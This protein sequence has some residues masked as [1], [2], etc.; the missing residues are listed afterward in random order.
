MLYALHEKTSFGQFYTYLYVQ[1]LNNNKIEPILWL[2]EYDYDASLIFEDKTLEK[3]MLNLITDAHLMQLLI[4]AGLDVQTKTHGFNLFRESNNYIEEISLLE[5]VLMN[6]FGEV[7]EVIIKTYEKNG[8]SYPESLTATIAQYGTPEQVKWWYGKK[9]PFTPISN[10]SFSA[11]EL[12][13]L[14]NNT[15]NVASIIALEGVPAQLSE[16]AKQLDYYAYTLADICKSQ[17]MLKLLLENGVGYTPLVYAKFQNASKTNNN[18]LAIKHLEANSQLPLEEIVEEVINRNN[19]EITTWI[20]DR[21]KNADENLIEDLARS[22]EIWLLEYLLSSSRYNEKIRAHRSA[23]NNTLLHYAVDNQNNELIVFLLE[24]GFSPNEKNNNGYSPYEML[25]ENEYISNKQE[26]LKT[27]ESYNAKAVYDEETIRKTFVDAIISGDEKKVFKYLRM[28]ANPNHEFETDFHVGYWDYVTETVEPIFFALNDR[29]EEIAELLLLYGANPNTNSKAES[30][31]GKSPLSLALDNNMH[32]AAR[33]LIFKGAN[34]E[35]TEKTGTGTDCETAQ[36]LKERIAAINSEI[37]NDAL[38]LESKSDY[39]DFEDEAYEAIRKEDKVKLQM[40]NTEYEIKERLGYYGFIDTLCAYS[41]DEFVLFFYKELFKNQTQL[42]PHHIKSFILNN[43]F[44]AYKALTETFTFNDSDYDYY[45][46]NPILTCIEHASSPYSFFKPV[47]R[48]DRS[49]HKMNKEEL[50]DNF[51]F[52]KTLSASSIENYDSVNIINSVRAD[53]K[54]AFKYLIE[55]NEVKEYRAF[56]NIVDGNIDSVLEKLNTGLDVNTNIYGFSLLSCAAWMNNNELVNN[57]LEKGAEFITKP[58]TLEW[59]PMHLRPEYWA[60]V[61]GNIPMMELLIEKG[62]FME[63]L[64]YPSYYDNRSVSAFSTLMSQD[65]KREAFK[66]LLEKQIIN[67]SLG[68]NHSTLLTQAIEFDMIELVKLLFNYFP[69]DD[70]YIPYQYYTYS[71]PKNREE[72]IGY[73]LRYSAKKTFNYLIE[74]SDI[75]PSFE[76]WW[77]NACDDSDMINWVMENGKISVEEDNLIQ[78]AQLALKAKNLDYLKEHVSKSDSE[79]LKRELNYGNYNFKNFIDEL[80][81]KDAIEMLEYLFP[82]INGATSDLLEEAIEHNSLNC[83]QYLLEKEIAWF[84]TDR[85]GNYY[86]PDYTNDYEVWKTATTAI[87]Q[88]EKLLH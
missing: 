33:M 58:E 77:L 47:I 46:Y 7:A 4:D 72:S 44:A 30:F 19:Q 82:Y 57:L 67:A 28:G 65:S 59:L 87:M 71:A 66:W 39:Y 14:A 48:G 51:E 85:Y 43:R 15:A 27:F 5:M 21:I 18:K 29:K 11:L 81:Q 8:L 20:L 50:N 23:D 76:F 38:N 34:L 31:K 63:Y 10:G 56:Q 37:L 36:T 41:S 61:N 1:A 45:K 55:F 24:K 32:N 70:Y 64:Y 17:T 75:I 9:N 52:I 74:T 25:L 16:Q 60:I 49:Q 78:I 62:A 54:E 26:L 12:A 42:P 86:I 83:F 6:Q 22:D 13:V 69:N 79:K 84:D 53:Y 40:L 88:K 68:D 2:K 73:A 35:F 3:G 80:I